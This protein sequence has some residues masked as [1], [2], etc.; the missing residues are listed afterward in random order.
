MAIHQLG[1]P[2]AVA[3]MRREAGM[4]AATPWAVSKWVREGLPAENV[5]WLAERTG[6]AFTP[7]ELAPALYPNPR[8]GL[9]QAGDRSRHAH[10]R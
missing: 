10:A 3:R 7:H 2:S 9:P 8:D 5:L 1:G 4:R 6:W